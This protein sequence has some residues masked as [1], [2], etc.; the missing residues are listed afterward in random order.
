MSDSECNG[1]PQP[2]AWAISFGKPTK[3]KVSKKEAN[4]LASHNRSPPP[5]ENNSTTPVVNVDDYVDE[6]VAVPRNL[7]TTRSDIAKRNHIDLV[8]LYCI[9]RP[10]YKRSCGVSSL[11]SVWNFLYSRVGHGSLPPVSQEEVMTIIGFKPP[12]EHIRW[13]PFTGNVTLM[14]WFHMLNQHFGVTGKTYIF[15]KCH[16]AGKTFGVS[17]DEAEDK[18]KDAMRNEAMALVYHCHNHYMVPIGYQ[19]QPRAQIHAYAPTLTRGEYETHVVIGEVSRGVNPSIHVKKWSDVCTDLNCQSP[20]FFDIRHTERGVQTRGSKA[21]VEDSPND[22]EAP[23]M[24]PVVHQGKRGGNLHCFIC[25]RSDVAETDMDQFIQAAND[26]ETE[27]AAQDQSD[28]A[29]DE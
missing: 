10:Q 28:D 24:P 2:Q 20:Q 18:F 4:A 23:P 3:R 5:D 14:R 19:E 16:G 29:A 7:S 15:W 21:K 22:C 6:A 27:E 12:F 8:R 26:N 17:N 9:S 13:G 25:F 11:T 1:V